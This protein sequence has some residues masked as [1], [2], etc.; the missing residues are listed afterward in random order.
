[1]IN[2]LDSLSALTNLL[3]KTPVKDYAGILKDF[4]FEIG[5]L[6]PFMTWELGKYTRNCLAYSDKYEL[7]LLCWDVNAE[8]PVHDHGGEDCWVYQLKGTLTE[9]RYTQNKDDSSVVP[10]DE[11]ELTPEKLTFMND[12][13]GYHA[14]ENRSNQRA[15]SLHLYASPIQVCNIFNEDEQIFKSKE[16]SYDTYKGKSSIIEFT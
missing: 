2:K 8:T 7:I 10:V 5:V 13:M 4:K 14:I 11:L 6:E 9:V 12:R 16:L 3:D 1:M 15:L